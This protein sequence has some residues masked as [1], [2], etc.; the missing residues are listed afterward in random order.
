MPD[1][2]QPVH[3]CIA[4]GA[5]LGDRDATIHRALDAIGR[6]PGVRVLRVSALHQTDAVTLPGAPAQPAYRNGAAVIETTLDAGDLLE[7]LLSIER[8]LG[9]DRTGADRWSARTIDLDLLFYADRIID[10]P[11][12]RVPHPRLH[13]RRFVLAPLAEVAPDWRHPE[14]NQTVRAML[15]AL[16]RSRPVRRSPA[17]AVITAIGLLA[18][19]HGVFAQGGPVREPDA[20]REPDGGDI[21]SPATALAQVRDAYL[22][23]PVGERIEL[24]A[25]SSG[26]VQRDRLTL[27]MAAGAIRIDLDGLTA[28][29]TDDAITIAHATSGRAHRVDGAPQE[30][31]FAL[32]ERALPPLPLPQLTIARRGAGA[33]ARGA[34]CR[35]H[36][37]VS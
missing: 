7:S 35:D 30:D 20:T 14:R 22:A 17:L 28:Q 15:Q 33:T 37:G 1:P 3:A 6:T 27:R 26:Q 9:R 36:R 12:L 5:N 32:L 34:L 29:V 2:Q 25:R 21:V 4:L 24:V 16:D 11:G 23:G 18:G 8:A 19:A 31:R 13:E 10:E